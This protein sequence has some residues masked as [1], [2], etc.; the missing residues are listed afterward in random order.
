MKK[1]FTLVELLVVMVIITILVGFLLSGVQQI[2]EAARRS[3]CENNLRQLALG[4]LNHEHAIGTFPS[5]GWTT[6]FVG[7]P[8]MGMGPN[9]PGGWLFSLLPYIEQNDVYLLAA[10]GKPK[11]ITA[12]QEEGA[13]QTVTTPIPAF[14]C[15]S[16][17]SP[18]LYPCQ[19]GLWRRNVQNCSAFPDTGGASSA[20]GEGAGVNASG[21][22]DVVKTDYI[23]N[24][25]T[26][27][28]TDDTVYSGQI[29]DT[30][31][32][33]SNW[34]SNG[35]RW[36]S[37][38]DDPSY[39]MDGVIFR[40]SAVGIDNIVDGVTN[41]YLLGEKFVMP[42]FYTQ[43]TS[44]QDL[45]YAYAGTSHVGLGVSQPT[46]D[47]NVTDEDGNPVDGNT[48]NLT[49]GSPHAGAQ[50][51]AFC[52]GSVHRVSYGISEEV[53]QSLSSRNDKKAMPERSQYVQ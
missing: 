36:N 10:D 25:G 40:R 43:N 11:T 39:D 24:A 22:V 9:Q 7:D 19:N 21:V 52:D 23:A 14:Y 30:T 33:W 45:M 15:A 48:M 44:N 47:W 17:R 42:Q 34:V 8:D 6:F 20:P 18:G 49:W 13:Y 5:S 31:F 35:Y 51:M 28:I 46:K 50:G 1:G 12:K 27:S 38:W 53:H 4:S 26:H 29:T 16:R 41:T 2:R 32:T 3:V 37:S